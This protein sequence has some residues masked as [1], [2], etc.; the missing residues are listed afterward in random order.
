MHGR[1]ARRIPT[2]GPGSLICLRCSF[3]RRE[4]LVLHSMQGSARGNGLQP[5]RRSWRDCRHYPS[6]ARPRHG[7]RYSTP[8]LDLGQFAL[9]GRCS[10]ATAPA[11]VRAVAAGPPVARLSA[12]ALRYLS[13]WL[14]GYTAL[15]LLRPRHA[16][17]PAPRRGILA[18]NR[19]RGAPRR[20]ATI[21]QGTIAPSAPRHNIGPRL[22]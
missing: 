4:I 20:A 8:R 11:A 2:P 21:A 16:H 5:E 19:C 12:A 13:G 7:R 18:L 22:L 3:L 15:H 6:H 14:A 1:D 9:D 17:R 10:Y